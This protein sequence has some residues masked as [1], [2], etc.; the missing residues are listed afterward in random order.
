[1][2]LL[3]VTKFR[4][5]TRWFGKRFFH[6]TFMWSRFHVKRFFYEASMRAR[7]YVKRFFHVALLWMFPICHIFP[8]AFL[9]NVLRP[10]LL[11]I[12]I[13]LVL[14]FVT[15]GEPVG[16]LINTS[17]QCPFTQ[18]GPVFRGFLQAAIT[19][20]FFVRFFGNVPVMR[21]HAKFHD[22]S[23]TKDQTKSNKH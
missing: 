18:C 12:V 10:F 16:W 6:E 4:I 19:V 1:M 20:I 2:F 17:P 13:I 14:S 5:K 9:R 21:G 7:Y 11:N 15:F 22:S 23:L 3:S 8:S